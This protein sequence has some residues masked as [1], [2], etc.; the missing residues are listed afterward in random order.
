MTPEK[1]AIL[2]IIFGISCMIPFG[3]LFLWYDEKNTLPPWPG[4]Y[5]APV[6][7]YVVG[8]IVYI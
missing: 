8:L 3:V 5:T 6:I 2:F 4:Q 1:R 7:A